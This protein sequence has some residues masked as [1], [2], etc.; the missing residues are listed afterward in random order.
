M[1]GCFFFSGRDEYYNIIMVEKQLGT[2]TAV[3]LGRDNHNTSLDDLSI[4]SV[5][6]TRRRRNTAETSSTSTRALVSVPNGP[7]KENQECTGGRDCVNVSGYRIS[8][9]GRLP[10]RETGIY[11]E[12]DILLLPPFD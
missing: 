2:S 12:I 5:I 3:S 1:K 8:G 6:Q 7:R 11:R 9:R 4:P 10:Y